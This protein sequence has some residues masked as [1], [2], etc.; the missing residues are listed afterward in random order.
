MISIITV[1]YNC[2]DVIEKTINSVLTQT[3]SNKEFIIVD[4]G[5]TDG[6]LDVI[7]KYQDE[8]DIFVSEPDNGVYDA[9]NKGIALAHGKWVNMMNAGD[10]FASQEVLTLIFSEIIPSNIAAIYSDYIM[11]FH[12]EK[13]IGIASVLKGDILHQALIYKKE[14]H[15]K[16]GEYAVT[17]PLI[18]S[19]FLFF[20]LI[21]KEKYL[22]VPYIIAQYDMT[23]LSNQGNW[24]YL[25]LASLRYLFH[26]MPF[27]HF[28]KIIVKEYVKMKTPLCMFAIYKKI[29]EI[30]VKTKMK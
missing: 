27:G 21:P 19:D 18:A 1:T 11:D 22:K 8:I 10:I 6:T 4:G 16:Y 29:K 25:Q 23:G 2:V 24:C 30:F 20:C 17:K 5:S 9:M 26:K 14:L 7:R 12:N 15:K 3:Y 13:K 28:V